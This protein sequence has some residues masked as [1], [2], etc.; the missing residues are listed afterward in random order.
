M[1]QLTL[2]AALVCVSAALFAADDEDKVEPGFN[3]QTFKGLEMRSIGP[4][5][6]SGRIADIAIGPNDQSTWYVGVGSGGVWKTTNRG[7]TWEAIFEDEDAYSIGCI[8]IDP[9]NPNT[10]WVGTGENIS[11]RHVGYGAGVYRSRDSGQNWENMGL[12]DS[13]HIGMIRIDPRDSN[14]IFVAAQGPLWSPGG[15][16]GLYKSTNGGENWTKVLGDGLGNAE[17]DDRYTGV[18]E[19]HMDPR[20]PDVMYAVAWQRFRN[21][22]VLM[23][24]GPATSIHKSE[25]GGETWR[26][27]SEGLPEETMGKT[28]LAISPQEPDVIYA[29]IELA[30]RTGAFYRSEDGGESWEKGADFA[31]GGTGPHYYNELWASPHQFDR[32]YHADVNLHMTEDGGK[33]MQ[34]LA[35]ETLHVDHHAMAFDPNDENYLLVGNDGGLYESYD[36]GKSW[37]Y[38]NN[39]PIT[40]YYKVAVDYDEPF[41][42][43]YGGTQDNNS[44]GGPSRTDNNAGIRHSDW[45]VTLFGD[46][47]QSAVDPNN[48]DIVYAQWQQGNLSRYDR[49]T[50]ESV[51]IRPQA[52]AGE[53]PDRYNWDSPILISPHDSSTLYFGT[54]RVWKSTNYGD[55]WEPVSGDLTRNENRVRQPLMGRTWSY[56]AH[57]DLYAMSMF[58]TI[59]SLSES[60]L[61]PGLVYVGTDD[62]LIQVS[63]DDGQTWRRIEK[64]RGVPDRFFVNDI[65]ADLHDPDTVYVVVD[66]HKSGDFSPYVLKSENRGRSWKSIAGNLPDRHILWRVVQDHEKPGLMFLGTEFG[67]FFTVNGGGKWTKLKGGTPNIP[68]RDLV[69]QTRENDL[70]GATFGRSFYI[71]DDYT[72]L[73]DVTE[74]MLKNDTVLFPVRR[75]HWY[76]PKRPLGC[77]GEHC[78]DSQGDDF[79]AA[80]NPPFGATFTYYLPEEIQSRKDARREAEKEKEAENES[81]EFP[82]WDR[83]VSDTREDEPAIV[84][85]VRNA[86]GSVIRHVDGPVEA[87]FHR[88]AWDLRYPSVQAWI[89]EEEREEDYIPTSGVLVEPGTISVSMHRRVGGVLT[90]LKQSQNFEVVSIREPTLPGSTQEQRVVF[91]RRV[92]ELVRANQGTIKSIDEIVAELDAAKEVLLSSTA[93]PSLY[94]SADSIQQRIKAER[95]RLIENEARQMYNDLEEMTVDSRLFHARFAPGTNA[96]GPTPAQRESLR[97]ASE[98]YD[99]V[100]RQLSNLVDV[101]YAGLK[102]AMDAAGVPWSPGRGIQ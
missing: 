95:D 102:V 89:P 57:W 69:I 73:R 87:G 54:Q 37:R 92:D 82:S 51:Y 65:K 88:V 91:D 90:D 30:N 26:K 4:A 25:D 35:H 8:T 101:E 1:K 31:A 39:L 33:T 19:V 7:T 40:Q 77:L 75:T 84:F 17:I 22:A 74:D 21:V 86:D 15:E 66:D 10:I 81:V 58:N 61:V 79:F 27:L 59:T 6:M 44:H 62:G 97:I 99:D 2:A 12:P 52:R 93:D 41:Y 47:H 96:Y 45:F 36:L 28:G 24:G 5:F 60:P 50:G 68:F 29:T 11:G 9:N 98:L 34:K 48:P 71:F 3:E 70:V 72:P 76:V 14:V 38:I 64:L 20:N 100:S 83:I 49:K 13:E 94:E 42:N 56:D 80:P 53:P 43:V 78:N 55:S 23:D 63:E 16:R 46:G 67:V 32:V 18:S 85:I